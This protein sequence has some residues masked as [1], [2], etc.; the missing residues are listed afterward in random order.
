MAMVQTNQKVSFL[1]FHT[2][3][4]AEALVVRLHEADKVAELAKAAFELMGVCMQSQLLLLLF[5]PLEF[6]LPFRLFPMK[7]QVP[8]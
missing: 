5:R 2:N 8:G 1:P 6:E 4:D 7:L 3:R